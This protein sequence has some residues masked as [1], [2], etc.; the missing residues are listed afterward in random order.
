[1]TLRIPNSAPDNLYHDAQRVDKGNLDL[2]QTRNAQINAAIINNH[3]GSGVLLSALQP[4]ILWDSDFL[5]PDQAALVAANQFDGIG[6]SVTNQPSDINLGNQLELELT[7][8]TVFGRNSCKI[9]I[10]GLDFAG[11]IQIDRLYFFKNEK[12]LTSKHYSKILSLFFNDFKGNQN[13]SRDTGGRLVIRESPSFA[14]SR[15][16]LMALQDVE[17][18]LFWRDFKVQTLGTSIETVIQNGIG[19]DFSAD[20]LNINITSQPNLQL[21]P[22]DVFSQIGQKFLATTD[23]VQKITLLLGVEDNGGD[24]STK[25]D[26][27]G[28]LLLSIYPLQTSVS[29][30][31][32]IIPELAIDFDPNPNSIVQLSFN[33]ASLKELGYVLTDVL[34]PVDFVI[35]DTKVASPATGLTI[36]NYYAFTLKR[37]GAATAGIIDIGVGLDWYSGGR[38]TLFSGVWVDVGTQDL[39][40]QIWSDSAKYSDGMGYDAGNGVYLPKTVTDPATGAVID[41]QARYFSFSSTGINEV[42]TGVI[43]A[44]EVDSVSTQDERTGNTVFSVQQFAPSFSFVDEAGLTSL[45]QVSEPLV[46]GA[47][48]DI[49]PKLNPLLTKFQPLPGLARG[50]TFSVVNPDADLLSLNLLGSKLVPNTLNSGID[51][52]IA[53]VML[54][55]DGYGDVNG[56]GVIDSADLVRLSQLVGESLSSLSTQTKI[57]NGEVGTLELLRA[58]VDGDGYVS[59][60]DLTLLTNYLNRQINGFP[61]GSS[62]NHLVMTVIESIGRN[63]SFYD[64]GDGY[65]RIDGYVTN[66]GYDGYAQTIIDT[67]TLDPYSLLYYG[68]NVGT[69]FLETDTTLLFGGTTYQIKP[70][71]YWEPWL[72]TISADTRLVPCSITTSSALTIGTCGTTAAVC[73]DRN[74]ITPDFNPGSNSFFVPGNLY[75]QPGGQV[76]NPDGSFYPVDLEIFPITLNLPDTPLDQVSINLFTKFVADSG[77]G[78]ALGG[79]KACCF[80]DGTLVS[81]AALALGQV[82]F[83]VGIQSAAKNLDGYSTDLGYG[84]IVDENYGISL[85]PDSGIMT[86]NL[87]NLSSDP[88]LSTLVSKIQVVV[89]LKKGGWRNSPLTINANEIVGLVS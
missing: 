40:F 32:D 11:N 17:P 21:L 20:G 8:S 60:A 14:L 64:C 85:D 28:D 62:F 80:A 33:Q 78:M 43:Q 66:D 26:W 6:V 19:N 34:Q 27:T 1:M 88:V 13:C 42:N 58:D 24:I 15:D 18:D 38:V 82:R 23:N 69:I 12:Q 81:T 52:R 9:A 63:D 73:I 29:C 35:N 2:E 70:Q 84:I 53:K 22:N 83:S 59:S 51:Y 79:H 41:N 76:L 36:G 5:S 54:C 55:V 61:V 48:E 3:F 39:W 10:V 37:A 25:F 67:S 75:L 77:N 72:L 7:D 31:S 65:I 4:A 56:D 16:P 87:K 57:I 68:N 49:N 74:D 71:P 89:Y 47:M 44:V 30:P 46:I 50:D 86:L 45:K